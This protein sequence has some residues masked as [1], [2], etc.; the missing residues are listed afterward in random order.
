MKKNKK[1]ENDSA[2]ETVDDLALEQKEQ[3]EQDTAETVTEVA[4]PENNKQK[5]IDDLKN[6][7]LRLQA[8]YDNFRR[9]SR[10]EAEQLSLFVSAELMNKILP[11]LDSFE[12]ALSTDKEQDA[13]SFR[14]GMEMIYRQLEKSVN[15]SGVEKIKA[16]GEQFDPALHE[17]MMNVKDANL[18]DGQIAF[19][20]ED[21]YKI[22][23]KVIRPSKVSVV[24]NS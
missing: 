6:R 12:R 3:L 23:D 21:G 7:L 5:E 9:R 13:A 20:M 8:D 22:K 10:T 18:P 11:V 4:E 19:V 24:K 1:H 16:V 17:A 15:D 2:E 14:Q